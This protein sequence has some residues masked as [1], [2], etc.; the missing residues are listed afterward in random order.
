MTKIWLEAEMSVLFETTK[1]GNMELANRFVRSATNM[2][3]AAEDGSPTSALIDAIRRL[4][5]GEV[6]LIITGFAYV[7]KGGQVVPG[8]LGCH[9][10]HLL[11]GMKQLTAAAHES[12]SR[13]AL[14]MEH[15]GIFSAIGNPDLTGEPALGPSPM[16]TEQGAL[17]REATKNEIADIVSGFAA[18]AAR[19]QKAGF[20]AVQVHAAHGFLLS[21]FLSPFF[22]K[23]TDEYGGV[24]ENRARL[25]MEVVVAVRDAMKA[26]LPILVK[27]NSE[28]RLEGGFTNEDMLEVCSMLEN[29]GVDA[30]E[31]SG[32]TALGVIINNPEITYSPTKNTSVYWRQAAEDYKRR[33][34]VPL[35]LVG[36]I[37]TYEGAEELVESEVADYIALCRPLIRE[38]DLVARWRKGD[39]RKADCISDNGC[40]QPTTDRVGTHC[41]YV[42]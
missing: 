24:V 34:K 29:A 36:G 25:L 9:G 13:I 33:V 18:A 4:A 14:Q 15:G 19:A 7:T 41:I 28:D 17:G 5:E 27:I 12:G 42:D 1:I 20:D 23:R 3:M 40:A 26:G 21:Q 38:P 11:P 16:P 2:S 39:R 30:I 8:M 10:D 35:I 6:G 31:L 37:R 22:N 32:G